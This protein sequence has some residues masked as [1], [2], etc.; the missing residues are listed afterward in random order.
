MSSLTTTHKSYLQR[1]SLWTIWCIYL[2]GHFYVYTYMYIFNFFFTKVLLN[3][4]FIKTVSWGLP[5]WL[6]GKESTRPCRSPGFDSWSR[7]TPRVT[8]Q[9]SQCTTATETVLRNP[10]TA[11]AGPT[12]RSYW[13][14]RSTARE[15]CTG[16]LEKSPSPGS[17]EDQHSHK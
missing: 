11:T 4:F 15:A 3:V 13:S 7:K 8:E 16:Q 17:N 6:N 12:W 1:K 9:L 14:P 2:Y 10:G 5:W